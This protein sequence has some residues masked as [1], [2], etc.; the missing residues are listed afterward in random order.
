MVT[1]A[2][3]SMLRQPVAL[4]ALFLALGGT[5]YAAAGKLLPANSV[6]SRQV[7]NHSLLAK[8][9]K[10][11]QVPRGKAGLP[12]ARGVV[13]ARGATGAQGAVGVTRAVFAGTAP[14]PPAAPTTLY[15]TLPISVRSA[16]KVLLQGTLG[17]LGFSCAGSSTPCTVTVGLYLDGK[18]VPGGSTEIQAN[19]S[20]APTCS[21]YSYNVTA[22]ALATHGHGSE[23]ERPGGRV[24]MTVLR[25]LGRHAIAYVA[26][27]AALAG[28]SVAAGRKLLPPS[29]VG[30]RQVINHSL[31]AKDF[32]KHQLRRGPRGLRGAQGPTGLRGAT[33]ARGAAPH[34]FAAASIGG[35]PPAT[36]ESA[37]ALAS[38][39]TPASGSIYVQARVVGLA[40]PC[41]GMFP[42]SFTLGLYLDGQ[43]VPGTARSFASVGSC[44]PYGCFAGAPGVTL[45]GV[46]A[47]VAA[48]THSV[49]LGSKATSGTVSP[50]VT[51][52]H[53][54]P[55]WM[56]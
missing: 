32:K 52:A 44:S 43:P 47:G 48:G 25:Q 5:S 56:G 40:G 28:T 22:F 30:S 46:V 11:G 23:P 18:P 21:A 13:G 45:T 36:L 3:R 34:G 41:G 49:A 31:L 19:I 54:T 24:A 9:F 33:G 27:F 35:N 38:L 7:I 4:L 1:R 37:L 53:L 51:S 20:C 42:C 50:T 8:D 12:G 2:L 14:T 29:T 16:G 10:R 55:V 6:G 39:T 17:F 15:A 26:L